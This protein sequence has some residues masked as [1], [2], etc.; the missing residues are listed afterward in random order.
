MENIS[1]KD[2]AVLRS[3]AQKQLELANGERNRETI[4]LWY[5]HNA[6][7][8]ERPLVGLTTWCFA[9]E[10]IPKR[11]VC[12]GEA[13]RELE[14]SLYNNFIN[15][16]VF[17]DDIPVPDF[18][19]VYIMP[20]LIP[21]GIVIESERA[22]S[23]AG[24]AYHYVHQIKD[25][26]QDF[27]LLGESRISYGKERL[28]RLFS[29]AEEVFGDILPPRYTM[30]SIPM[31]PTQDVVK[32]MGM[33]TMYTSMYDYPELFHE[34]MRRYTDQMKE[35]LR[36]LERERVLLP[37][38]GDDHLNQSS[39]C[40]TRELPDAPGP[41]GLTTHD[42]WG[43]IDSQETVGLSPDMFDE[44]VFTYYKELTDEF[45]LISYGCCEP[46]HPIWDKCLSRI[47][48]LRKLSISPW[49]DENFIAERLRERKVVYYRKPDATLLGGVNAALDEDA[50]RKHI[51]KT[52]E[53]AS[54]LTL[55]INQTDVYTLNN[56]EGKVRRYVELIRETVE[57]YW[58]P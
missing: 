43:Y 30:S 42:V 14:H 16:E 38:T 41:N 51:R 23:G 50:V 9:K 10:V 17:T 4:R 49:C 24:L 31:T 19:P 34:M 47:H 37:T 5:K 32:L 3:L 36:C 1:V 52:A 33:E 21:F 29:L 58:K 56:N 26:E 2:R 20:R 39:R 18:F 48:N 8:G 40:F 35:Q 28:E 25:L 11:L 45:G 15:A 54:G 13:A 53:A 55:E 27:H 57:R 7:E 12:E 6:C 46:A 22:P 44:F